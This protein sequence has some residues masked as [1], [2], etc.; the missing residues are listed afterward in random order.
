MEDRARIQVTATG[1][2]DLQELL[3]KKSNS[4][5]LAKLAESCLDFFDFDE[6]ATPMDTTQ[7]GEE[8][9]EDGELAALIA[10]AEEALFASVLE[11]VREDE[12]ES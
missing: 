11:E 2:T 12:D 8:E 10:Q 7:V 9:L 5:E 4:S 1:S 6:E 3:Q